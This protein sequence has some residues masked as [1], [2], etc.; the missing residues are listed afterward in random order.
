M[1]L[2]TNVSIQPITVT[3]NH[4]EDISM[5]E[6][7]NDNAS[8]DEDEDMNKNDGVEDKIDEESPTIDLSDLEDELD[9][10]D[11]YDQFQRDLY[12]MM[13]KPFLSDHDMNEVEDDGEDDGSGNLFADLV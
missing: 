13:Y 4:T 6:E 7:E 9:D 8:N 10:F 11:N 1:N 2:P 5:S 12:S 3:E